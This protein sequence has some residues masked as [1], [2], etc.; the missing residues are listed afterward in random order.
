MGI[1]G[2]VERNDPA[3]IADTV[4]VASRMEGLTKHFGANIIISESYMH[5]LVNPDAFHF[6]YLGQVQVKG[7]QKA[8]GA[9][10][11][12]DGDPEKTRILKQQ[13]ADQFNQGLTQFHDR[14]FAQSAASFDQVVQANP[15]DLVAQ[16]F[17]KRSAQYVLETLPEEWT[18]V[19]RL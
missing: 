5:S 17:K 1:I 2:D 3:T 16:Y 7:K 6:R 14:Q 13:F 4:N 9:Y 8:I 15:N 12:F 10:E 11:C 18:G 19:E